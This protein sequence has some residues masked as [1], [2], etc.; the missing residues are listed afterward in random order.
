MTRGTAAAPGGRRVDSFTHPAFFYHGEAGF[1]A[2][3]G[4]FVRGGVEN[5]EPVLVGVPERR[6][7]LL[8]DALGALAREVTWFAP[9]PSGANPGRAL[10]AFREFVDR[11]PTRRPR[12]VGEPVW[13]GRDA[14]EVRE[15]MRHEAL[16]NLALAG[17]A[18]CVLCPY[19]TSSVP[20]A[21][22][23][24]AR[25]AHPTVLEGREHRPSPWYTGRREPDAPLAEP[26]AGAISLPYDEEGLGSVRA[27]AERWAREVGLVGERRTDLVLAIAEAT[28][29]SVRHGGG[30]GVLR[31]WVEGSRVRAETRD[32]GRL[33]DPLAGS[34][35]PDPFSASGG[36]GLWMINRLCDLVQMRSLP[37]GLVI[38]M[39]M[40]L[41]PPGV[42]PPP[43]RG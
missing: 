18:A 1:L 37:D 13:P 12:V 3:V 17:S 22:L 24:D 40:A 20:T 10:S 7:R 8:R 21:V 43:R 4:A 19:D 5:G 2:G 16:I 42:P 35:R 28:T 32:A 30:A 6:E 15:A 34:N 36:R 39:T 23:A 11:Y 25:R 33:A 41:E 29:N 14:E 27:V 38:R 31:L 26:P 9:G